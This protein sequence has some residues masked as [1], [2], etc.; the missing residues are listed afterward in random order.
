MYKVKLHYSSRA[1]SLNVD[2]QT[3]GGQFHIKGIDFLNMKDVRN[4][5]LVKDR[6]VDCLMWVSDEQ[7]GRLAQFLIK[8]PDGL[9]LED[10]ISL[11]LKDNYY[12]IKIDKNLEYVEFLKQGESK[13]YK[14]KKD[15]C[16]CM[17]WI[18]CKNKPKYCK[19][20]EMLAMMGI[21]LKEVPKKIVLSKEEKKKWATAFKNEKIKDKEAKNWIIANSERL[22]IDFNATTIR[23]WFEVYQKVKSGE[24][25]LTKQEK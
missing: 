3:I 1:R 8:L 23:Q 21:E 18:F 22:I 17:S 19:H 14:V 2:F 6:A 4:L 7:V 11:E 5:I 24:I 15:S 16:N 20:T 10:D 9:E 12:S 13:P 25:T